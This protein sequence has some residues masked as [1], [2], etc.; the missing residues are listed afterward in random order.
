[1]TLTK[2]RWMDSRRDWS[3]RHPRAFR[4]VSYV[5][6]A[7]VLTALWLVAAGLAPDTG[8][9]RRYWY[10]DGVSTQPV[11]AEGIT[12]I[13]LTFIEEQDR[14]ARDYR[15]H[16]E[17]VRFSPR[18][19]RV[20]FAAGADDGVIL[21]LDGETV[22]ERNPAVGMHTV[23]RSMALDAG[24]HHLEIEHWQAGGGRNLNVEWAPSSD[25]AALLSATR[26]FPE[27]PGTLGYWLRLA[28]TRLPG[29]LLLIWATGPALLVA[30]A[31]WRTV[32]RRVTTLSWDEVR[33]RLRA[34]LFP[35]ILGPSQLLLFGPWTVHDTNRPEFLVGFWELASGW[36][37]LLALVVGVPAALGVLVPARWFPRYVASLCAA[38][39]LLWTQ[40]NLLLSDY[41][42]LDGGGLDL[43]SHGW[44]TPYE[45]GL[46]IGVLV[47]AVAFADVVARTA[48]VAS[49]ILVA[50]QTVVLL[51]PTSGEAPLPG[52]AESPQD[53]AEAAWQ[54]PPSEI[55]E[56][57]STRNLIHIVLDSFPSHTFAEILDADRSAYDRDWP[58]FTFFANHLGTQR[59]TRH[60]MP[61]MLTGV[62]FA[63]DVTFSEYVARHP[64]VFN[65]LGQEGYRL[66]VL[67]SYGGNQVNPAFPGVD[68]TIRYAIPNP[69]GGYRDYVDFTGAQLLDLSLL[70]HVPHALKPSVYRDQQWLFQ[71]RMASQRGPEATAEPPFGDALFLSEFANRITRGG[72]APVY[73]FVHLLTPHPPIVTDSD[74]RYA[75]RRPPR[76]ED[77]V[78]QAECTLSAVGALLRRLH[79]LD[80]Y[81]Q[82]GIIV[83][84][85]HGVN[86]RLNPLEANHPFYGKPSPH[87][88]VTFATVQRRAAPLLAVKPIAAKGPLQVSDAPTSAL[89]VAATLLD[90]ADI[91]G[92]LGNGVSVLRMDPATPRQRTYAHASTSF[93]VLHVF[94]VNGH[95]NDPN[96][97]SYY[98]SVFEPSNDPA[99]QRRAH[100]IGLSA[101]PMSTTAQS[102]GRV[103][104]ADEYAMFY[105]APENSRITFDVRRIAA[106]PADQTVTVQ[107][108]GQVVERRLLTDDTWHAVSYPV[109]PR[110]SDDSP[111]CIELLTSSAQPNTE[112]AS[113]GLMLRGNI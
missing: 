95:I 25:T 46:W 108:D 32:H 109:E 40:G 28:A 104:R 48:S 18:A 94:A 58:G 61:A 83:T 8:L 112:G 11:V 98:R 84:S 65:V 17:G 24:A 102:R 86:V 68:G 60:S 30:P 107:I 99:A 92:S 88:V 66:R 51:I 90:L 29:L 9:T 45:V 7:S 52:I 10:P 20:E 16:W 21:R 75:P 93:D 77:F 35:A 43:V 15:V 3:R 85:D 70:R 79:E 34:V 6:A 56:L 2:T 49:G 100:W 5:A 80:L 110:P 19:E 36:L 27:D 23:A 26:L 13:D 38:G 50:L 89:D 103:Y 22:V 81:D 113:S 37:W 42:V 44:R 82:T 97:W 69:Y 33:S 101:E 31:V 47:L 4:M 105:A 12:A 62:S 41:G 64:S 67:S 71:E 111:F 106:V 63:N 55:F 74:C 76:P 53:R 73:T 39:V 59:T 87:G 57:S 1:M 78:N 72:S 91:P 54:L 14:P 96:A